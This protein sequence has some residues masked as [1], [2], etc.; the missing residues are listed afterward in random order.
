MNGDSDITS[1]ILARITAYK[2]EEIA[3]ARAAR[4]FNAMHKMALAADTPRG[5]LAALQ[6]A[7]NEN[8]PGLIAEIK[9]ASPSKGLIRAN[10]NSVDLARAFQ[11][12]GAR[13]LSVLT[14]KPS[15]HGA[16][17]YLTAARAACTLPVLRK[18]FM[19]D[20]YQVAE[21]RSWGADAILIIMAAVSD[22]Q[23]ADL[24]G[25]AASYGMDALFEVHDSDE[26]YRALALKP[27]LLGINNRNLHN[28]ETTLETTRTLMQQVP[29]DVLLVSESGIAD[30]GDVQSLMQSG[31]PA[32]LVG[33]SLL[34]HENVIAAT[35]KLL[36]SQ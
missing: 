22:T 15:F 1:N 13:C 21:A 16:P 28:F 7:R 5:F 10:F 25:A 14:D 17:E 36:K 8:R 24:A 29:E 33:A 32:F 31:V 27:E 23:A 12:G 18:D 4:P 2:L 20:I 30:A 34:Q 19:Y 3:D 26:L 6:K 11:S 9:K 35:Q